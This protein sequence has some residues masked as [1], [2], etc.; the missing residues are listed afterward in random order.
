M[1]KQRILGIIATLAVISVAI[2]AARAQTP[3]PQPSSNPT[4]E[5][6]T[7]KLS[8]QINTLK[9]K[10]ASR[11][12]QLKLVEKKGMVGTVKEVDSMQLQLTDLEG[13]TRGVDVDEITKFS[14]PSANGTFGISD[15]KPGMKLSVI[16]LYNKDSQRILAR[17]I[18]VTTFPIQISGTIIAV[19]KDNYTVTVA[20]EDGTPQTVDIDSVTK[21]STY[22]GDTLTRSGFSKI[23]TNTRAVVVGF[24][25]IKEKNRMV[26]TRILLFPTLPKDPKV[27]VPQSAI[28][29]SKDITPSSGSGKKLTP[30]K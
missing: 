13:N 1:Y 23:E 10:I 22:D 12:A 26:A 19:D 3:T 18:S 4:S 2:P 6:V 7:E 15:I 14:S 30:V 16:G 17:Y 9:E 8:N 29:T 21:T 27:V 25:D 11:V 5:A 28:D 20:T 24:P